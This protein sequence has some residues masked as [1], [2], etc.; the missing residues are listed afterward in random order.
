MRRDRSPRDR[1]AV[2]HRPAASPTSRPTGH[3]GPAHARPGW[4]ASRLAPLN[5]TSHACARYS[6]TTA[7]IPRSGATAWRPARTGDVRNAAAVL[8]VY[9]Y[10]LRYRIRRVE[11][12]LGMDVGDPAAAGDPARTASAYPWP[13]IESAP[14]RYWAELMGVATFGKMSL[15]TSNRRKARGA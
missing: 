15:M 10:T 12:I 14:V 13:Q 3:E 2:R 11:E 9:P 7:N 6:T 5:P 1:R 4:V 8:R